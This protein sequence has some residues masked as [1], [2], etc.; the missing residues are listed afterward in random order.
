MRWLAERNHGFPVGAQPHEVVPI[1][2]AAVLFDL[3]RSD[4]GNRPDADFG[5]AACEAATTALS[6]RARSAPVPV[7]NS[8]R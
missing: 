5:Y 4:W 7:R 3:P 8:G 6:R 2:P 1:V